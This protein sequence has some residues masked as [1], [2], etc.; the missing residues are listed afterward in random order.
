MLVKGGAFNPSPTKHAANCALDVMIQHPRRVREPPV[1]FPSHLLAPAATALTAML[2]T[3]GRCSR[4]G[5]LVCALVLLALQVVVFGV[6]SAFHVDVQSPAIY[7]LDAAFLWLGTCAVAKRLHDLGI[8]A[9]WILWA[10]LAIVAW[11]TALAAVLVLGLGITEVEPGSTAMIVAAVG[12]SLPVFA[13]TLWL[14]L[15]PGVPGPNRYGIEPNDSGFCGGLPLS[16]P[17][18]VDE[19]SHTETHRVQPACGAARCREVH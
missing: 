4:K 15:T 14:H 9:R 3:T 12:T 10:A 5:L 6:V 18:H 1:T 7:L 17:V 8:S 2:V 16:G 19:V 11:A 13:L